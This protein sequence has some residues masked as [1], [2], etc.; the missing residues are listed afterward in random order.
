MKAPLRSIL[1]GDT[2]R[3]PSEFCFCVNQGMTL[4]GH[5][6]REIDIRLPIDVVQRMCEIVRPQ[7][8]FCHMLLWSPAGP[9][10]TAALLDLCASWRKR[11][12]RV[13]IHDGDARAETRWPH[14]VSESVDLALCNHTA[15]RSTWNIPQLR[16]PYGA[17]TQREMAAPVE[18]FRCRLAFAGRLGGG[19]YQDRTDL[20]TRCQQWLG[21]DMKVFPT[22]EVQHTLFRTP[23]LAASAGAVLGF[24]RP[25]APGWTDVRV[26]Q[27][28]GSGGVLLHDD[29]QGLLEPGVH[30]VP[31]PRDPDAVDLKMAVRR[32]ELAGP[33]IRP[34]AFAFVQRFHSSIPRVLAALAAVG[35]ARESAR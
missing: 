23:E 11:G 12:T 6:H 4:L 30:Y 35:L 5:W 26:T 1:I 10:H 9:T 19:I 8:L 3:Y 29:V 31:L 7:V 17:F 22:P 27:Y 2:S 21:A 32:A 16:W 20:V 25:E 14:D 13:L 34:A 24:G 33:Q 18:A 28:P 15:D